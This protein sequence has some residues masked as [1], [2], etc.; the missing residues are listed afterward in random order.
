[1]TGADLKRRRRRLKLTQ[2]EL[3][4]L[5]GVAKNTV[6][7]WERGELGMSKTTAKLIDLLTRRAR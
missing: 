4:K 3:A 6:A 2:A 5:I 1:M 7:R